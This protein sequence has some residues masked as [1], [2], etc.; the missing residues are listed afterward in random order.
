MKFKSY[1]NEENQAKAATIVADHIKW[2]NAILADVFDGFDAGEL[3]CDDVYQNYI[4]E[5]MIIREVVS[6]LTAEEVIKMNGGFGFSLKISRVA[7]AAGH[8]NFT[9][10]VSDMSQKRSSVKARY[11]A[12]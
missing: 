11:E 7:R 3:E 2:F 9:T 1:Q 10:L 12:M 6:Q 5:P 4:R 8:S